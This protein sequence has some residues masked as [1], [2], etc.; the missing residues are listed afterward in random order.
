MSRSVEATGKTLE[1]A[2]QEALRL[3]E[4]SEEE[5]EFAVLEEGKSAFLGLFGGKA[6]R[7]TATVIDTPERRAVRFLQDITRMIGAP[8]EVEVKMDENLCINLSGEKMGLLIGHRG[9]TLDALQYLTGVVVNKGMNTSLRVS[10][11]TENYR[12]RREE[13]LIRLGQK[14]AAKARRTGRR[15]V[16][17][18]MNPY[19]R[20]ILHASL[21]QNPYV[22]THSEGDEPNRRVVIVPR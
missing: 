19:E 7:V 3:L 18:P 2:K 13:T 15:V 8:A 4:A 22:D 12:A 11:D 17:E 16:L 10:L 20:R 21:Q 6:F 9:E 5:V 1:E 14:M